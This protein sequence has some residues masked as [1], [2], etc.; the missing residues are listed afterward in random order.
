MCHIFCDKK[1]YF[2]VLIRKTAPFSCI[3]KGYGG[4]FLKRIIR[5]E[6]EREREREERERGEREGERYERNYFVEDNFGYFKT[7][8]EVLRYTKDVMY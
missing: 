3:G 2:W 7:T 6:R 8:H 4:P 1:P 5:G